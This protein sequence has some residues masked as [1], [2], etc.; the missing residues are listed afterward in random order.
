VKHFKRF[1]SGQRGF[2]LVELL[3]TIPIVALVVAAATA[4]IISIVNSKDAS[5]SMYSLR[6]VQ[7]AGYWV[8]TD[9]YQAQLVG[10]TPGEI[11]VGPDRGFPLRLWWV[12]PDTSEAHEV[13][14]TLGGTEGGPRTLLRQEVITVDGVQ[15]ED[16]TIT[17]SR[18]LVDY[19][20][21]PDTGAISGNATECRVGVVLHS[22]DPYEN[23]N[24]PSLIF[25][26]TAQVGREPPEERTYNIM[27]RPE[28][29]SQVEI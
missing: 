1:R 22:D 5:T 16:T 12:D 25:R 23:I 18:Y 8:S 27:L 17:V 6:Q 26:V 28:I 7:T 19:S 15:T 2:T 29:L 24:E 10:D 20:Y 21:D 14:Y 3:V 9:G 4:G 13:V 11:T